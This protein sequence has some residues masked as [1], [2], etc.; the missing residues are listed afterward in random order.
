MSNRIGIGAVAAFS[1]AL[2][3]VSSGL[4]AQGT[5]PNR[6]VT[7]VV[8]YAAGG[9]TDIGVRIVAR[10]FA[11][12]LG[13]SVVVINKPG[14][15]TMIGAQ[16]VARAPADGYTL[17]TA[18]VANLVTSP[19]LS[20]TP[21]GYDPIKDFEP[22]SLISANPLLLVAS[23][24]TDIR[25]FADVVRKARQKPGELA[26]ASYG[27][28]TPSHLAIELLKSSTGI[29]VIH[30]PYNG[31]AP[32]LVDLLGGRVPLLM[33]I[34]PSHLKTIEKG[35]VIGLA[36]GQKSRSAQVPGIPT[37]AEAGVTGFEATT[38][39][40]VA[41][42]AGTSRDIVERLNQAVRR[43]LAD[44]QV[45]QALMVQG[46]PVQPTSAQEFGAIISADYAKW[47]AVIKSANITAK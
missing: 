38:W 23:S 45:Q 14:A 16:F 4:S 7:W 25:T 41:A 22:V 42:P 43:T 44:S 30:V 46:M 35:D 9:P 3:A 27:H 21:I 1:L 47:A 40:G 12:D 32:A 31:A 29:D 33:D 39:F 11:E 5:F 10:R 34:L 26:I 2:C 36:I 18:V 24:K 19:L 37:F 28:G 17:L 6:P 20:T 15:G 13:Q 8:P